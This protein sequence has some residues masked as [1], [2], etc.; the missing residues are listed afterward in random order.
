MPLMKIKGDPK[1][2]TNHPAAYLYC[3]TTKMSSSTSSKYSKQEQYLQKNVKDEVIRD[4]LTKKIKDKK[5]RN[6]RI[7]NASNF[8]K[9]FLKNLGKE[10]PR[11]IR[12]KLHKEKIRKLV[13]GTIFHY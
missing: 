4:I 10:K 12:I 1:S 8:E 3:T 6:E 5:S 11:K 13:T 9:H 2:S 7:R